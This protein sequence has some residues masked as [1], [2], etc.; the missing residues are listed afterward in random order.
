MPVYT[1]EISKF[2]LY[3]QTHIKAVH[4]Y[5]MENTT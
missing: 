3:R 1:D 2:T 4:D 5:Q